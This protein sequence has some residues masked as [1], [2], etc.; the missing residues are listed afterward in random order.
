MNNQN[1]YLFHGKRTDN[2]QWIEGDLMHSQGRTY[3]GIFAE[4]L[5]EVDPNTVGQFTGVLDKDDNKI[6][7]HSIVEYDDGVSKFRGIV[8]F[9]NGAFGIGTKEEIPIQLPNGCYCDHFI[10]FWEILWNQDSDLYNRNC[11]CRLHGESPS[12]EEVKVI[13]ELVENADLLD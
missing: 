7:Q 6:W 3:C 2:G 5:G 4:N 9:E 12:L 1:S 8:V 13:G 11:S 10:S